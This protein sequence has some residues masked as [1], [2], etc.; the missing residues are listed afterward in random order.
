MRSLSVLLVF[1]LSYTFAHE[2]LYHGGALDILSRCLSHV[3]PEHDHDG[4]RHTDHDSDHNDNEHDHHLKTV[5]IEKNPS[6]H[7][8]IL[9]CQAS[10]VAH[11]MPGRPRL[12]FVSF[13]NPPAV[14]G[15]DSPVQGDL[16]A[17]ILRL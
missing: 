15:A 7:R 14:P 11:L 5:L 16:R 6:S 17:H 4:H 10:V 3:G 1:C 8:R 9:P 2:A 13:L 12:V